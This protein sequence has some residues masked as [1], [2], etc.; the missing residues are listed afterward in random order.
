MDGTC[1][2]SHLLIYNNMCSTSI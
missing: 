2:P 1:R